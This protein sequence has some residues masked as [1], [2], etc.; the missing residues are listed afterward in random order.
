MY[1]IS[2][3][4]GHDIQHLPIFEGQS[5]KFLRGVG[6]SKIQ[7]LSNLYI[8]LFIV[9]ITTSKPVCLI[10]SGLLPLEFKLHTGDTLV[11]YFLCLTQHLACSRHSNIVWMDAGGAMC[12]TCLTQFQNRACFALLGIHSLYFLCGNWSFSNG[13]QAAWFGGS[14]SSSL[15]M[16]TKEHHNSHLGM[17]LCSL[18][19]VTSLVLWTKEGFH[20]NPS[21]C[22]DVWMR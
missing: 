21:H 20:S 12:K 19:E 1:G 22:T 3:L 7:L 18:G 14:I 17:R 15:E 4:L 16:Q 2:L 6:P 9:C 10:V 11:L 8:F 5:S 13:K